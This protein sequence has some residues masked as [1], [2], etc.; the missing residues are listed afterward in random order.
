MSML[1]F[2]LTMTLTVQ[3]FGVEGYIKVTRKLQKVLIITVES[4]KRKS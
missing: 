3:L 1:A 2:N 4:K